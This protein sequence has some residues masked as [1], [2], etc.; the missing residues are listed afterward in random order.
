MALSSKYSSSDMGKLIAFKCVLLGEQS[1][2]K[3]CLVN[4]FVKGNFAEA[5][6]T[7]AGDFKAKVVKVQ[8]D[9]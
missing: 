4:R 9:D 8:H 6:S 5:E 3:T 7:I 1:V 2:G